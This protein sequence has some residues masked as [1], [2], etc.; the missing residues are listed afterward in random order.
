M[1]LKSEFNKMQWFLTGNR[2]T[3]ANIQKT[4]YDFEVA[5]N[6]NKNGIRLTVVL[7]VDIDYLEVHEQAKYS[8]HASFEVSND[9]LKGAKSLSFLKATTLQI[10]AELVRRCET[11]LVYNLLELKDGLDKIPDLQLTER[12]SRIIADNNDRIN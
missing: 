5:K 8:Q 10:A 12:L 4:K 1:Q 2:F 7:I 6:I 11:S 9:I 3:G